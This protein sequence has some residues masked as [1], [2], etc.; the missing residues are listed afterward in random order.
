MLAIENLNVSYDGKNV[1]KE[2]NLQVE[3]KEIIALIGPSGTG[4]STLIN[5]VMALHPIDSGRITLN[6]APVSSKEMNLAWIPQNYGLLPWLSVEGNI[7]LGLTIKK[8]KQ[9]PQV[10]A[11]V[12]EIV[13]ELKIGELLKQYPS[14]LSGGQQQRVSIARAMVMAADLYLLDEPF[15]ALDA[16]TRENMQRLFLREWQKQPAPAILITHDVEEA[17]FLGQRIALLSGKPGEIVEI[18]ENDSFSIPS[19]KK[20]VSD[21]FYQVTKRV[22]E[23]LDAYEE[24][25]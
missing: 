6:E 18:I 11:Q 3:S 20:R 8:I 15:S 22:R 1:L 17:V 10:K 5:S 2:I 9:T 24:I 12:A 19:E 21:T 23:V 7:L 16:I 14:Q 4:K 13:A 25:N